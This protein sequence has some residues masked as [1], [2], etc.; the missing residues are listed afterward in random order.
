MK[1]KMIILG[2]T[3]G[4]GSQLANILSSKYD[5][6][7]IGSKDLDIR[8]KSDCEEFFKNNKF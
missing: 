3:G 1:R 2:G 5:I 8:S 4:L 7:S 6:T